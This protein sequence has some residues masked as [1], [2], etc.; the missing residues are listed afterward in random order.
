MFIVSLSLQAKIPIVP[1]SELVP[2]ERHEQATEVILHI[3]NTYH[4]KKTVLDD[5]FS[6]G[7][8]DRYIDALDPNRSIFTRGDIAG[9][10]KYR[11]LLDDDLK[12]A[13]LNP[14]FE[15]FRLYRKRVIERA[16]YAIKLLDTPFDFTGVKTPGPP[17]HRN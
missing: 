1:E 10:N 2:G 17:I 15:M 5:N 16:D 13:D 3:I 8:L 11:Y 9:F 7:I 14:A 12:K 4:Y 6:S